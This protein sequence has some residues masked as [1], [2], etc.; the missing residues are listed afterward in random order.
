MLKNKTIFIAVTIV[1][2]L[3][4]IVLL[5]LYV[6]EI[7][8]RS[9][10][11]S[12]LLG[13]HLENVS[14]KVEL[15]GKL[16]AESGYGGFIH[17]FKNYVLRRDPA[18][19][20]LAIENYG[21]IV[22]NLS[23]LRKLVDT[24]AERNALADIQKT[25][26]AY[27]KRLFVLA[28]TLEEGEIHEDDIRVKVDD[29][30]AV[31]ALDF[32][33]GVVR[34][35][36]DIALAEAKKK[37][38]QTVGFINYGYSLI[39]VIVLITGL[40]FFLIKRLQDMQARERK[41]SEAKSQFL[42]TMSHEIRTPLNGVIGLVQLL[43][44][45]SFS[46]EERSRLDM[47]RSSGELLLGILNDILDFNKI[48]AGKIEMEN[49]PTDMV[50]LLEMTADFYKNV[51][52]ERG[53]ALTYENRLQNSSYLTCDPT[54]IRQVLSSILSNAV[55]FTHEGGIHVTALGDLSHNEENRPIYNLIVQVKDTGIGM[56]RNQLEKLF[57]K[58][59]QADTSISRKYG[60]TGLGMAL[61]KRLTE[62]MGGNL[63]AEST[64]GKGTVFTLH[65]PLPVSSHDE[66]SGKHP[67][68]KNLKDI[69]NLN[70]LVAEDNMVNAV[71]AKGFLEN[72]G[73]KVRIAHDGNEAVRMFEEKLPD[74]ILM[75]VNMPDKS[76]I[77]ATLEVRA[78][79]NG[80]TVPILALT[81]DAFAETHQK[82]MDAGMN[83][84]LSKPFSYEALRNKI[85]DTVH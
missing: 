48:E 84:V 62:W 19:K 82:C 12:N 36:A 61:S 56:D 18:Y 60:G 23:M 21:A 40:F 9:N 57:E 44:M 38:M 79:P 25:I 71:V 52:S 28:P 72:L 53:L 43:N 47:I 80:K 13:N 75:D 77:E 68:G 51:A 74:L 59:T 26:A 81:A 42:S 10:E 35:N 31:S 2:V 63:T 7:E 22:E 3:V 15:L 32:L 45:N 33:Y 16:S 24:Q 41:A 8:K 73:M 14:Q 69:N 46:K 4:S 54:K 34:H 30:L 66:I 6:S 5:F 49:I 58:Y 64:P 11:V 65:L 50:G 78:K 76:G 55:K 29:T 67:D 39:I 27:Y 85:Y 83:G 37:Q 20:D 70:V 17:N 1:S